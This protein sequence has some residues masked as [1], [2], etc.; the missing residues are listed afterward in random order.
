MKFPLLC[1]VN[2]SFALS[3]LAWSSDASI[4]NNS[5]VSATIM[6]PFQI[7]PRGQCIAEIYTWQDFCSKRY[8]WSVKG[9]SEPP[10]VRCFPITK[11]SL[12]ISQIAVA[13]HRIRPPFVIQ[14]GL[15]QHRRCHLFHS[16]HSSFSNPICFRSVWCRRTMIPGKIFTSC[17][18]F[19]GI[20]SVNDFWFPCWLQQLH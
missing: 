1:G 10:F 8:Y 15:Q 5:S 14:T 20:V 2:T 12:N 3:L 16:A 19:Q 11:F 9:H 18:K 13:F 6:S 7:P 4:S 17:A